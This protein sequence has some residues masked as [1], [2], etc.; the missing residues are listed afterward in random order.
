MKF[1]NLSVTGFCKQTG[2]PLCLFALALTA[3]SKPDDIV[4]PVTPVSPPLT[5]APTGEI[6]RFSVTDSMIAFGYGSTLKW[7]VNGTNSLTIVSINNVK[8]GLYGVLDTG[9]LKQST[10]FT[11]SVN[12][13]KTASLTIKVFDSLSTALWNEG[14]RL[15]QTRTELFIVPNGQTDARWVDTTLSSEDSVRRIYFNFN[16]TSTIIRVS[17]SGAPFIDGGPFTTNIP[18]S[19]FTWRGI[20]Y[21]IER[22]DTLGLK[23]RF[24][25][26]QPSGVVITRRNTYVYE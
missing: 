25:E 5:N 3:C 21:T 4:I 22:L 20:I 6:Q 23:I 26:M 15:K 24:P 14:R 8:V 7:L 13:G 10:Q 9:P 17:T 11:L 19:R 18:A 1:V 2:I 12:N 16:G